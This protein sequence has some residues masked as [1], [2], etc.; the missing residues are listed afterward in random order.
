VFGNIADPNSRVSKLKAQ[1]RDYSVLDFL[2]TKPR[3][4]YLARVRNPNPAM[5]D[6][7]EAPLTFLE[8]ETKNGDPFGH[9]PAEAGA[10]AETAVEKGAH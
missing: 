6:Y 10:A 8:F 1:Q 4:T 3:T 9:G 5:P 7:E 2:E